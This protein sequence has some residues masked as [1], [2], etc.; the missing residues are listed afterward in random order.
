MRTY[1]E[2]YLVQHHNGPL[3]ALLRFVLNDFHVAKH[4]AG[5]KALGIIDK[6]ITGPFWRLLESATMSILDISDIII[7]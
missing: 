1:F 7:L 6:L 4:I 2:K 3:N 5:C